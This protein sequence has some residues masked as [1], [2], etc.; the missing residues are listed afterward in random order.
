MIIALPRSRTTWLANFLTTEK[1][2]C[3][4]DPLAE[5]YSYKEVLNLNTDRLTGIADTGI[6]W[7]DTSIF[8]CRKL[9]IER[10]VSDVNKE[11]SS[12]LGQE[13]DLTPLWA[14]MQ[15]IEALRVP[16]D[17][18]NERLEEIWTYCTELPYDALRAEY[19]INM[20]VQVIEL[21]LNAE[22]LNS[23]RS[24]ITCLNS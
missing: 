19:L 23:L 9:I 22:R 1:T 6:G 15:R 24:E 12:L 16:F 14:N 20:N 13:I 10:P 18:I 21:P 17:Q 11:M 7:F 8:D 4:H 2:F 5:M 3:F